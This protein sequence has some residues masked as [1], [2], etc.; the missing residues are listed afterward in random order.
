MS[1]S[2]VEGWGFR[3]SRGPEVSKASVFRP[4]GLECGV[5]YLAGGLS[6]TPP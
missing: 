3:G 6:R 5:E 4:W 2:L 1:V